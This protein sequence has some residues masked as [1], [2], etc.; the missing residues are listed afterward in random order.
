M[1]TIKNIRQI[2]DADR[3]DWLEEQEAK[4]ETD[5]KLTQ[6]WEVTCPYDGN[7]PDKSV[8]QAIDDAIMDE[9]NTQSSDQA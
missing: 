4:I 1:R 3:L 8:R 7:P 6:W 5:G 9:Q 2:T